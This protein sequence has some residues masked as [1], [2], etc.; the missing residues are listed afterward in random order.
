MTAEC[1]QC[2]AAL[3]TK[4]KLISLVAW[5]PNDAEN[6][7][8]RFHETCLSTVSLVLGADVPEAQHAQTVLAPTFSQGRS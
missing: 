8:G 3:Q 6:T 1:K 2:L 4:D 5:L 7:I